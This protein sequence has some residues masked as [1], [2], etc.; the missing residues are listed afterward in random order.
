[1]ASGTSAR[2][3]V[4]D[5]DAVDLVADDDER[6]EREPPAALD[7][8]GDAVDLDDPLLELPRLVLE[9][10]L[11]L[12]FNA[13]KTSA[14]P[15]ARAIG[16]RLDAAVVEVAAAV[17]D[18]RSRRRPSSPA[19]A[20]SLPTSAACSVFEPLK[21]F[22]SSPWPAAASVL[23]LDVV[24]ELRG[25]AAVRAEDDETRPLGACRR[26]CGARGVW[27]RRRASS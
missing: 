25:D 22:L 23:P 7:D 5:A 9:V 27:R 13:V 1:M 24:H 20:S 10:A 3:P 14:L 2:L 16:E 4:A 26:P 18:A 15:L 19:A 6:G 8:L 17:E 11:D 21:V 12:A